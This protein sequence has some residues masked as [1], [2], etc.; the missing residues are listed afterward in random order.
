MIKFTLGFIL[1]VAAA[2]V[3]FS[4]LVNMADKGV[5]E[6][7]RVVKDVSKSDAASEVKRTVSKAVDEVSK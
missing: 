3:G 5:K 2:T 6:T 1:G 7:Q 4:G